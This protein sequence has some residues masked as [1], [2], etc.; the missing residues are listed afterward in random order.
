MIAWLQPRAQRYRFLPEGRWVGGA[1]PWIIGMMTFLA[2]LALAG[3]MSLSNGAAALTGGLSRSFTVQ[4]VEPN[5]DLKR[6]Q[7]AAIAA[8]LRAR[9]DVTDVVVLGDEEL[10][11]LVE[12][13]LGSGNI[14]EDLPLPAMIDA[15][16]KAGTG[17]TAVIGDAVRPL[18]PTARI[19]THAQWFRPLAGVIEVLKWLA[20][21]IGVLV[22]ATTAAIVA[23]SVRA[24]LSTH[25]PTI[26]T[27]HI[28]GAEDRTVAAL[29]EY[30]YAI[31]GLTGSLIGA[32]AGVG[33]IVFIGNLLGQFGGG[34]AGEISLSP[35]GWTA[36][37][38]V[39]L[40]VALLTIM[41][42]RVTVGRRL[43]QQL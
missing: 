20:V 24:A 15:R 29:F 42:V 1:L 9:A 22:V 19:D 31:Q 32:L 25:G 28:M 3:G 35:L 34:L 6:E 16:W 40:L 2:T 10:R 8:L 39:P 36:L 13:W 17:D 14:G 27:L 5:P 18:A 43:K 4:I 12:P 38:A 26:E 23:L 21:S 41:T 37:A 11:A 33:V 30:R 7:T